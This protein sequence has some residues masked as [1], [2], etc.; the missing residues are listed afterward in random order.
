[1]IRR[2]PRSTRKES[3]AASDV[4]KRQ[5]ERV[6][7]EQEITMNCDVFCE[8]FLESPV[9]CDF[10]C[11]GARQNRPKKSSAQGTHKLSPAWPEAR[12]E[13]NLMKHVPFQFAPDFRSKTYPKITVHTIVRFFAPRSSSFTAVPHFTVRPGRGKLILASLQ[14]D[15]R[16]PIFDVGARFCDHLAPQKCVDWVRFAQGSTET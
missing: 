16:A 4:Y 7:P 13:K 11:T 10:V 9:D 6:P 3:S 8:N 2:P 14:D 12:L 5:R 1:M 15:R